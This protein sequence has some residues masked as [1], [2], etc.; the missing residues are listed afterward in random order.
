MA[1]LARATS[2]RRRVGARLNGVAH[3]HAIA[4]DEAAATGASACVMEVDAV[5]QAAQRDLIRVRLERDQLQAERALLLQAKEE[6][7]AV[8]DERTRRAQQLL[9]ERTQLEARLRERDEQ[10]QRLSREL[11]AATGPV[12]A[13][14]RD[15]PEPAGL[16]L[17]ARLAGLF[18]RRRTRPE[19][20]AKAV[21]ATRPALLPA[22]T[23]AEALQPFI[24]DGHAQPLIA[25]ILLGLG[26]DELPVVLGLIERYCRDRQLTPVLLT[27]HDGLELFRC[28]RML[29]EYLPPAA[30]RDRVAPAMDWD[31]YLQRRLALIRRKWQP[32]RIIAFGP[33][34]AQVAR[35]WRGSPFEDEGIEEL[36]GIGDGDNPLCGDAQE[37]VR[38]LGYGG[39]IG[40]NRETCARMNE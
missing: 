22:P 3:G 15:A 4:P 20:D 7:A 33:A 5:E 39:A 11:G 17:A 9:G 2:A 29:F 32:A 13:P 36:I 26:R 19:A 8:L 37:T 24:K 27:D 21:P 14:A 28:R 12:L 16:R 6:L 40:R 34:A 31:L 18:G 38:T 30:L 23:R 10:V 25:A 1:E 35:T